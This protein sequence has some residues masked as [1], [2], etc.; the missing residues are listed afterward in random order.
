M[1]RFVKS[2]PRFTVI[3]KRARVAL[4]MD[5]AIE[6]E[7]MSDDEL[8]ELVRQALAGNAEAKDR[9]FREFKAIA[10]KIVAIQL[11]RPEFQADVDDLIQEV[12]LGALETLRRADR[13]PDHIRRW[14]RMIAINKVNDYFKRWYSK[15]KQFRFVPIHNAE[16]PTV[17]TEKTKL[18][19][20]IEEFLESLRAEERHV[21]LLYLDGLSLNEIGE[22]L[23]LGRRRRE[24][25]WNSVR[26]KLRKWLDRSDGGN[27]MRGES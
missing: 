6:I 10:A 15:R 27:K 8:T 21:A 16:E 2:S 22:I 9:V 24:R 25:I 7:M 14:V 18:Q 5:E 11:S 1:R 3:E 12:L 26:D 13:I 19:E 23:D 17:P 20:S 4:V